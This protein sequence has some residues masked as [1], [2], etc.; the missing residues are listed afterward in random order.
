MRSSFLV[1]AAAWGLNVPEWPSAGSG[2][3]VSPQ[4][5]AWWSPDQEAASASVLQQGADFTT[6]KELTDRP[7]Q[8]EGDKDVLESVSVEDHW[9]ED[10][11]GQKQKQPCLVVRFAYAK[12][13]PVWVKVAG[14]GWKM[15]GSEHRFYLDA[16]KYTGL[17]WP[18]PPNAA[19][20]LAKLS[21]ISLEA[22]K[23]EAVRRGFALELK[24]AKVPEAGD[25]R[26]MPRPL[27]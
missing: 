21:F 23:T 27:K 12:D 6:A 10:R 14:N 5:R 26:P 17:F 15:E 8:V 20:G 7:V 4:L 18:A 9:V 2:V 11:A 3:P 13:K 1:S 19:Q 25:E 16:N 22:F 24:D